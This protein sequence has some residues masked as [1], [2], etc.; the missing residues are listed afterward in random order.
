MVGAQGLM[1][2]AENVQTYPTYDA[3]HKNPKI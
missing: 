3:T 2:S 1:T